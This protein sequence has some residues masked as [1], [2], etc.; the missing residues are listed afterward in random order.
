MVTEEWGFVFER[1]DGRIHEMMWCGGMVFSVYGFSIGR[2]YRLKA[3]MLQC[4]Y[5]YKTIKHPLLVFY[6][7]ELM[8]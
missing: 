1:K 6:C 3:V 5:I 7:S 2:M 4:K 8:R